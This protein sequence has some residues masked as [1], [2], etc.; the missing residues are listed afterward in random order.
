VPDGAVAC[1]QI[2][3]RNCAIR[4]T[5]RPDLPISP[6]WPKNWALLYCR[7]ALRKAKKE[8]QPCSNL[9]RQTQNQDK[10][11]SCDEFRTFYD[12]ILETLVL[13]R[14]ALVNEKHDRWNGV[15]KEERCPVFGY[16]V[17]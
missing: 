16:T 11:L 10:K 13:D 7:L 5:D 17:G 3:P 12:A 6:R 1:G 15:V 14:K 2:D 9:I 8:M 4:H